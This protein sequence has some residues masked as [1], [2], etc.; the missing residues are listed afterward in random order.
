MAFKK[1]ITNNPKNIFHLIDTKNIEIQ[2]YNDHSSEDSV[3][4]FCNNYDFSEIPDTVDRLIRAFDQSVWEHLVKDPASIFIFE[5]ARETHHLTNFVEQLSWLLDSFDLNPNQIYIIVPD[6][7]HVLRLRE[8]LS[9]KSIHDITIDFYNYWL[10]FGIDNI[11]KIG[12]STPKNRFSVMSRHYKKERLLLFLDLLNKG[13]LSSCT[14]TFSNIIPYGNV[15]PISLTQLKNEI[16]HYHDF[17]ESE[18]WINNIPYIIPDESFPSDVRIST[19]IFNAYI[20]IVIETISYKT[21]FNV[22]WITEKTYKPIAYGKPFI[23]FSSPGTLSDLRILGFKTFHPYIDESY[24][25]IDD[26][27]DRRKA[28]VSEID[29]IAKITEAQFNELLNNTR[30]IVEHNLSVIREKTKKER[31]SEIKK[32]GILKN[33]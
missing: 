9:L 20:N 32:L 14:Y 1:V 10:Y 25:L 28:V 2:T 11:N 5:S 27:D 19:P 17:N 16:L 7:I 18:S 8:L 30:D 23:M 21:P 29:R 13:I 4:Y 15:P 12:N 31:L 3:V 6:E 33:E 22:S 26:D 24:D